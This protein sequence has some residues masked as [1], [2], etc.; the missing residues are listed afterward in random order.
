MSIDPRNVMR[1]AAAI[2]AATAQDRADAQNAI[3][4]WNDRLAVV[5]RAWFS[6][7]CGAALITE[8]YWLHV[9]CGGCNAVTAVDLRIKECSAD[10][11]ISEILPTISC[12][13]CLAYRAPALPIGLF[14]THLD[15]AGG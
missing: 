2:A 6:P 1:A 11:P 8:S 4:L 13:R 7:T 3:T 12:G 10:T 5:G 14:R 15:P 9:F